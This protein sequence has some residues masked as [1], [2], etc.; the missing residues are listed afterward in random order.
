[1]KTLTVVA[2]GKNT[3]DTVYQQLDELLSDWV[4]LETY[5]TE[6]KIQPY[7]GG[8]L[9]VVTSP[10]VLELAKQ[11]FKPTCP[12][13]VALR[14]INYL[15]IDSLLS[16]PI[17]T[18]ALL[19]N[20]CLSAAEDTIAL[21]KAIGM[22][23]ID[24]FPCAPE[25]QD[26]PKLHLAITPGE[27]QLVPPCA[28]TVIDIKCRNLDF[29]TLVDVVKGL[30]LPSE[31]AN[32]LSARYVRGIIELIKRNK[33]MALLN[34]LMKNQLATI[35][36]TVRD[37]IIALNEEEQ[38]TVFNSVAMELLGYQKTNLIGKQ[39]DDKTLDADLQTLLRDANRESFARIKGRDL[40]V[41]SSPISTDE[42]IGGKVFTLQDVTVIQR[43]EEEHRR[44]A[45]MSHGYTRYTFNQLLGDSSILTT[46]KQ[47]AKKL[48]R[49]DSP[50]LIQ[51]ESGTGKELFAQSIH[52]ASARGNK[53]FVAVNFAALSES[54]L[55]SEL[56]GY[57]EGAFTGAKKGGMSGLFQQAHTGTIFLDE[58]GDAP[59]AFQV[60]LLRVLQ[61]KQI[62]RIGSSRV[63]PVDVRVI[64]ATNK[65][66]KDL[67]NQG[68]F[69]QDLYYRLNVLPL[70]I[71][72]LRERKQDIITLA[73]YF[74]DK[75]L[76]GKLKLSADD[77]FRWIMDY[78]MAYDWPGNIRE[79]QNVVEYLVNIYPD[80]PPKIE[81]LPEDL[82][83][84]GNGL[85]LTK[86]TVTTEPNPL[87]PVQTEN[88]R[89]LG[90]DCSVESPSYY[91]QIAMQIA[92]ANQAGISVGRRSLAQRSGIPEGI[93]RR[94]INELKGKKLV[95]VKRG[96]RGLELS[97][98][99]SKLLKVHTKQY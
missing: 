98:D 20:N 28:D 64:V 43:L 74:Y 22:N 35:I 16:L 73:R 49:S 9:I 97:P 6:D 66:L 92:A 76:G 7:I 27:P 40:I 87:R 14:S 24:Y 62:R 46:T 47:L 8:D 51:G 84:F 30:K 50:I 44:H 13:V 12:R 82:K 90:P 61:E 17:G 85:G 41:N 1:M 67:I 77:Y 18:R 3:C 83:A 33:N 32:L 26:Y 65:N 78:L 94:I 79:L 52:N 69:R 21:L 15:G 57:E 39:L 34:K 55:E 38:I 93:V 72:P 56:F 95:V 25:M 88:F 91:L 96:R 99:G 42:E 80:H 75:Y 4:Q 36:N 2:K 23:H 59:S 71:P 70:W 10:F 45:L 89:E 19:V 63:I 68:L 54:L 58:I 11:Y 29:I 53:P 48:A 37:G 81:I 60:K 5:R 31:T 86:L